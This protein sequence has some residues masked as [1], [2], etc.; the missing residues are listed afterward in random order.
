LFAAAIVALMFCDRATRSHADPAA[1]L[2]TEYQALS[3]KY[4]ASVPGWRP[5]APATGSLLFVAPDQYAPAESEQYVAARNTY[6]DSLF[7]LARRAASAGQASLALQWATEAVRENPDHGDARRVLS[8]QQRDGRWL[9]VY[10]A[11]MAEAGKSWHPKF[12]W[13]VAGDVSRY[14]A[15]ERFVGGKWVTANEDAAR[16]SDMRNGWQVRTDH[17][18]VTTNHSLEAAVELATRLERLHQI[19]RQLFAGFYLNERGVGELFESDREPRAQVRPFSVYYHRDRAGYNAALRR[20]QPRIAETLGIYFDTQREAHFFD[21]NSVAAGGPPALSSTGEPPVL[22]ST[23]EPPV[24]TLY[25][26]A[27]HQLFQESRPAA[28][29]IGRTAN[30]WI[31]EGVAAYF[32]TLTEHND[33]E[34]GLYYTIGE[35]TAGRMPAA[36]ARLADGFYMP[37]AELSRF[38]KTDLQSHPKLAR[39]YSQSAGLSAL[40]LHA[41]NGRYREPLVRYLKAV[42]SGRDSEQT[43]AESTGQSLDELD[44]AYRRF[45]ESLP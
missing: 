28:K 11:R 7:S 10:G 20:R 23:T 8:Y 25:H 18:L 31:V 22:K 29:Q 38:G 33:R 37:L 26:E 2:L 5:N 44:A 35:S 17:F 36:R 30:F 40:L 16:H 32:E 27:V 6:A 19:W 1:E 34:A 14:E 45:L 15:G 21:G 12:G 24:A 39:L 9:T 4:A 3:T 43:L 13:I 41:E 42:Y